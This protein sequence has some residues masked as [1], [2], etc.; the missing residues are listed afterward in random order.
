MR[1]DLANSIWENFLGLN[2]LGGGLCLKST[3]QK[4]F[5]DQKPPGGDPQLS[6][7]LGPGG[8]PGLKS[9][10]QKKKSGRTGRPVK[11]SNPEEVS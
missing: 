5:H 4:N 7:D 11:Y 3:F 10:L 6:R 8:G 2:G 9:T 1:S